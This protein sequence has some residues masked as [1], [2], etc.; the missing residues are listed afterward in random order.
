MAGIDEREIFGADGKEEP[1]GEGAAAADAD[2]P[3]IEEGADCSP[4]KGQH[5]QPGDAGGKGQ[6]MLDEVAMKEQADGIPAPFQRP[7]AVVQRLPVCLE[8][9]R[10]CCQIF[11]N[12]LGMDSL[13]APEELGDYI[14]GPDY[15]IGEQDSLAEE[16]HRYPQ[17]NNPKPVLFK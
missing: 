7:A 8:D 13:G 4:E 10:N 16:R 11:R 5:G 14:R 6:E 2:Q 17:K 1:G 15:L 12:S 9:C 3:A